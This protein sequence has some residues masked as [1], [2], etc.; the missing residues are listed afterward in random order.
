MTQTLAIWEPGWFI[1]FMA[2]SP[3]ETGSTKPLCDICPNVVFRV[4]RAT[5]QF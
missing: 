2:W 4:S 5:L 3:V 1:C